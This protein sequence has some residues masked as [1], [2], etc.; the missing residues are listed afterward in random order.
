MQRPRIRAWS[1]RAVLTAALVALGLTAFAAAPAMAATASK[2]APPAT[3]LGIWTG[4]EDSGTYSTVAGQHPDIAN[5]YLAWGQQ[6]PAQFI[7][8]AEAAGATPYIEIEGWH[9]GPDGNH[10][11]SFHDYVMRVDSTGT[12][13]T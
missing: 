9:A 5:Y 11:P 8:Q 1:L 12:E 3:T 6:W 4:A 2:A 13:R 7:A 10:T